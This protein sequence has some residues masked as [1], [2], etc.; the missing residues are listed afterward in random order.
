MI[1]L[2]FDVGLNAPRVVLSMATLSF[3]HFFTRRMSHPIPQTIS[4]G[5]QINH[6][7][8]KVAALK[9]SMFRFF[10]FTVSLTKVSSLTIV[11]MSQCY[12]IMLDGTGM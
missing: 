9:Y 6:A 3:L 8:H 2:S 11:F 5:A 4:I 12:C 10:L 7:R 1:I